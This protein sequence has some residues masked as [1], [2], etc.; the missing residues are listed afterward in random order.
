MD[1]Q[2]I[3][4]GKNRR[5]WARADKQA[6]YLGWGAGILAVVLLFS[7]AGPIVGFLTIIASGVLCIA[8]NQRKQS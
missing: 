4:D 7:F 3:I 8:L 5:E 2:R 6:N 1:A